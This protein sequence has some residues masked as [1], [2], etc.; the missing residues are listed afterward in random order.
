MADGDDD[1]QK[2]EEPTQKR[3]DDAR[4]EGQ[5][6]HSRELSHWFMMLGI[7][8]ITMSLAANSL[9]A[10][11]S[12]LGTYIEKISEIPADEDGLRGS[13]VALLLVGGKALLLPV[14]LMLVLAPAGGLLQTGFLIS[15][16]SLKPSFSKISPMAGFK[17]QFSV[18]TLVEFSKNLAKLL[19]VGCVAAM[20]LKP[21]LIGITHFTGMAIGQVVTETRQ[22]AV[23]LLIGVLAVMSLI[24]GFD[25]VYQRLSFLKSMRMSK[26]DIKEEFKQSEGNPVIKQRVRQLRMNRVRRRMMAEVPKADVII[27]NPTHY[28]LAMKYDTTKMAAPFVVAK[29]QDNIALKIREVAKEHDIPIVENPPLARALYATVEID[30]EITAEHYRAVAEVISYVFKLKKRMLAR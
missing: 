17:R 23:R 4:Q 10:L 8:F 7:L 6:P 2:T 20:I 30:Q 21:M 16:R 9:S 13:L 19:I 12:S 22:M 18:R 28:A 15:A 25:V 27:T 26:H 29:G 3:L 14:L 5:V 24:A 1:S 11:T